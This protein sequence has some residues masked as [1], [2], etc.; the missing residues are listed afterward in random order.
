MFDA[1]DD[2]SPK[3]STLDIM[4]L[5]E[6]QD[7]GVV[8]SESGIWSVLRYRDSFTLVFNVPKYQFGMA[9]YDS[10]NKIVSYLNRLANAGSEGA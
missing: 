2:F 6:L 4:R 5:Q 10:I 1:A 9:D 3:P 8:H 7:G